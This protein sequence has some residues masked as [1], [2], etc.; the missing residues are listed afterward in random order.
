MEQMVNVLRWFIG[1]LKGQYTAR[2]T[3]MGSEKKVRGEVFDGLFLT[4][5]IH[6]PLNPILGELFF[7][8]WPDKDE[9]GDTKL[10]T[11]QGMYEIPMYN[12]ILT[13]PLVSHHPPITAYFIQNEKAGVTLEGH[14]GQRTSFSGGSI[15]VKQ[16]GHAVLRVPSADKKGETLYLITLPHLVIEGLI[17]GSPYIELHGTSY[18]CSSTGYLSTINYTGK[19]YFSGK[20]HSFKAAV[21]PVSKASHALYTIEGD[22]SGSSKFKGASPAGGKDSAFWDASADREEVSVRPVEEQEPMESRK[23]WQKTAEG[24]KSQNYDA[25]SKDK[26]RIEVCSTTVALHFLIII[27]LPLYI[28]RTN[29]DRSVR[30]KQRKAV[31]TNW[32]ILCMSRMTRNM[33]SSSSL[34]AVNL[35]MKKHSAASPESTRLSYSHQRCS[36]I[37]LYAIGIF[38]QMLNLWMGIADQSIHLLLSCV[39]YSDVR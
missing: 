19:G 22:W 2:N 34:L 5:F 16:V 26:S 27:L 20:A 9:R 17:W 21:S 15:N 23:V 6:Q 1:T 24:I 4:L 3:S 28:Y 29:R 7:G 13:H 12:T 36:Y 14:S 31:H 39:E 18:I 35:R 10:I 38:F 30:T 32:S 25:A 8:T 33:H 11:E 37:R